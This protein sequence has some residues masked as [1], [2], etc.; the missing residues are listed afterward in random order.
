[1]GRGVVMRGLIAAALLFVIFCAYF[2]NK[3]KLADN[4]TK[5]FEK[6]QKRMEKVLEKIK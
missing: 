2:W 1:M 3:R 6:D 4:I 5:L